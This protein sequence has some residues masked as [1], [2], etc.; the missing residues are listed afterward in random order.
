MRF[1]NHS[2]ASEVPGEAATAAGCFRA[3]SLVTIAKNFAWLCGDRVIRLGIGF[4]L[5]AAVA[6]YLG[7]EQFGVFTLAL[8]VSDLAGIF[9]TLGLE[10]LLARELLR[11][12][13]QQQ[14]LLGT[15]FWSS[16][17]AAGTL[18]TALIVPLA[19]CTKGELSTCLLLAGLLM[20]SAPLAML[21]LQFSVQL[22]AG[23]GAIAAN[24]AFVVSCAVRIWLILQAASVA[25]FVGALLIEPIGAAMVL[26]LFYRRAGYRVS[27]W[28]W[29]GKLAQRLMREA[30]PLLLSGFAAMIYMRID[31]VML[32]GLT[33]RTEVGLYGAAVRCSEVWYFLPMALGASL[34][35]ALVR[36]RDL[37]GDI[38]FRRL[39]RY[40]DLNAALAYVLILV[41]VPMAPWLFAVVFG[42]NY[43][44]A[45]VILQIH[46]LA[47]LFV[48]LGVARGQYLMIEGW[49]RFAL[50]ATTLGA[51]A[52]VLLNL[53]FIP[54]WGA[55]GA[56]VATII[57]QVLA[58]LLSSFMWKPAQASGRCQVWALLLPL[59]ALAWVWRRRPGAFGAPQCAPV[60]RD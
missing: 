50:V 13:E 58:S 26:Y 28:R 52:N 12:P 1:R 37:G 35:P 42:G 54:R 19:Q 55:I 40:Y 39:Q 56:A 5:G 47:S 25:S 48:F 31:Q 60:S 46:I 36:S 21:N 45:E 43:A 44:G 2:A 16:L 8:A 33:E 17:V 24:L 51:V 9:A 27:T 22:K 32:A 14:E 20:I 41:L 29:S 53:M 38:Y 59:R 4:L 15:G 7:P 57:S 23:Y 3:R 49:T 10:R 34:L 30:W 11:H 18:Y 6:R